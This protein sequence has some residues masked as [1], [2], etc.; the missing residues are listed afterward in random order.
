MTGKKLLKKEILRK[1]VAK[2]K[3]KKERIFF[4]KNTLKIERNDFHLKERLPLKY[5]GSI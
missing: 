4:Y 2:I 5:T 1:W 3:T